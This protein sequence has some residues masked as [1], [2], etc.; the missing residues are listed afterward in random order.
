VTKSIRAPYGSKIAD[1]LLPYDCDK[2]ES[3]SNLTYFEQ[4]YLTTCHD[5]S[6]MVARHLQLISYAA[7][8]LPFRSPFPWLALL[9]Y[10]GFPHQRF[11][12]KLSRRV[13]IKS[14]GQYPL[15]GVFRPE[16]TCLIGEEAFIV[17]LEHVTFA[18][19]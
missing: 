19:A 14:R 12:A 3:E 5:R 6:G 1:K 17:S 7:A 9:C 16:T 13:Y 15:P 2:S 11:L 18:K 4:P 8:C 10:E